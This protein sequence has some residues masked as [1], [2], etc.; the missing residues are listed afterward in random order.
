MN[1]LRNP[2]EAVEISISPS[3]PSRSSAFWT[4]LSGTGF[5]EG[6]FRVQTRTLFE[7][8]RRTRF[9]RPVTV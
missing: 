2:T 7:S 3:C 8:M 4:H 9:S 5:P 1:A 6:D